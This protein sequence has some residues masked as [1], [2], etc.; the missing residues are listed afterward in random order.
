[1]DKC[2]K[3]WMQNGIWQTA[4]KLIQAYGRSVGQEDWAK[5]FC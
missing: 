3:K 4:L 5:P 1:M 2:K